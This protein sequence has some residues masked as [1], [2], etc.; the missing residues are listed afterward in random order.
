MTNFIR[1]KNYTTDFSRLYDNFIF[2]YIYSARYFAALNAKNSS[3]N[4]TV[5]KSFAVPFNQ[6][7]LSCFFAG[8]E[9]TENDFIWTYNLIYGNCYRFNTGRDRNGNKKDLLITSKPGPIDGL[10]LQLN[11]AVPYSVYTVGFSQAA[12]VFV[13]NDTI[14]P[15]RFEGIDVSPGTQYAIKIGRDFFNQ[16][17]LPY[18]DCYDNLNKIDAFDSDL[19]RVIIQ[20]NQTYRQRDCYRLCFQKYVIEKCSCCDQNFLCLYGAKV[21][22]TLTE[23]DCG[24]RYYIDFYKVDLGE[25]CNKFW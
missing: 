14:D 18:N 22:S 1:T 9:C 20:N 4:D 8:V 24:S 25:R 2:N 13:H 23:L 10:V 6:F 21:C 16:L 7:V 5:K 12:H 11:V 17:P 19:F 15:T 3:F